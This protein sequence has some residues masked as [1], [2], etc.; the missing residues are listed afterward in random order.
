ASSTW[1]AAAPLGALLVIA[2]TLPWLLRVCWPTWR[3]E[4]G[5]ERAIIE[6][7]LAESGVSVRELL[8]WETAGRSADAAMS[9]VVPPLRYLFGSDELLRCLTAE[10]L[11]AITAHEAA[12]CR[13]GHLMRLGMSLAVPFAALSLADP[14]LGDA[15][16]GGAL[17]MP[18]AI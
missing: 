10:Q 12:H 6:R 9:G 7:T 15:S 3:L 5:S 8:R 4:A 14:L 18:L 13:H 17:D 11:R 16:R 2:G 1:T